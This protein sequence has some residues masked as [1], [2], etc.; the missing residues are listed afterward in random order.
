[1]NVQD[2][3][4]DK[5]IAFLR[6]QDKVQG[7]GSYFEECAGM[8]EELLGRVFALEES[9]VALPGRRRPQTVVDNDGKRIPRT[10]RHMANPPRP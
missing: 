1:M 3:K 4:F 6:D 5:A 7:G 10:S 8:L 2:E 9:L